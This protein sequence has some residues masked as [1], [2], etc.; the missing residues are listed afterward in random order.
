[1]GEFI[2]GIFFAALNSTSQD[3]QQMLK[4]NIGQDAKVL[5][6][7]TRNIV[8][9]EITEHYRE[10]APEMVFDLG[11]ADVQ[12]QLIEAWYAQE[13]NWKEVDVESLC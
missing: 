1:M 13:L 5:E 2:C 6:F 9:E 12:E 8:L 3:Y 7:I 4:H 10:V 11:D